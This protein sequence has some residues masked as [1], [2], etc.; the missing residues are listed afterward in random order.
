[1]VLA[2]DIVHECFPCN[3]MR[4]QLQSKKTKVQVRAYMA[5]LTVDITVERLDGALYG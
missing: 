2:V 5:V 4:P 1:M 3:K